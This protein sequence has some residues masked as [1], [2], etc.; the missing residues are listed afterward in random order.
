M[1]HGNCTNGSLFKAHSYLLINCPTC[2]TT[3]YNVRDSNSKP[4]TTFFKVLLLDCLLSVKLLLS[5][6]EVT[7]PLAVVIY[8]YTLYLL[9]IRVEIFKELE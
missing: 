4:N 3:T 9:F 2:L 1:G 6:S 7:L 8:Y 5:A